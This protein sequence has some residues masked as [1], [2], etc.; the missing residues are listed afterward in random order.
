MKI[1]LDIDE[2]ADILSKH[3]GTPVNSANMV[4]HSDPMLITI[5]DVPLNKLPT[6][7]STA[8]TASPAAATKPPQEKPFRGAPKEE[9]QAFETS[10]PDEF[11]DESADASITME[12]LMGLNRLAVQDRKILT[13]PDIVRALRPNE[14][15]EYPGNPEERR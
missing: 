15:Y 10:D 9:S 13:N 4:F 2:L 3:L 6:T 1:T 5:S 11:S 14:S 7:A 12:D 8:S